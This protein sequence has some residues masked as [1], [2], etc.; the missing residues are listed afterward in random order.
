[1]HPIEPITDRQTARLMRDMSAREV[2]TYMDASTE[3]PFVLDVREPW[4]YS[5][6]HLDGSVNIPMSEV[7]SRMHEFDPERDIIVVCHHG[8][9]SRAVASLLERNNFTTIN[10][11]GGIDAWARELDADMPTY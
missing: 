11:R 5:I 3:T 7:P 9:R 10:L 6:V 8:I 4:E 2:R 1:M